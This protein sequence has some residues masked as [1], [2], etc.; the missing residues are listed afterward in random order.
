[1][2]KSL[3]ILW[4]V[5]LNFHTFLCNA[6]KEYIEVN[7]TILKETRQL[8]IQLPRN[9]DPNTE[10][11]YPLIFVFDGD[12]LF[13]PVA[14]IVD[15]LSY[16][17]EIPEAFVVGIKQDGQRIEDG[18]YDKNNFVPQGTG[19]DFF[20]FIQIEVLRYLRE[21][22]K[23]NE[24]SVAVGHNYMANFMNLFLF[25][26][27]NPFQGFINLSPD[28]PDGLVPY[29]KKELDVVN[30]KIWY[31][32]SI[33]S[34]DLDFLEKKAKTINKTFS[35]IYNE[36]VSFS[37]KQFKDTNHYSLVT[38]AIPF[39]L[40]EIFEIYGPI[41]NEEYES[42]LSKA[43]NP[44]D[45]LEDKYKSIYDL[46]GVNKTIRIKDIMLVAQ[47]IEE[48]KTPERYK[49][50]S[51]LV[52]ESYPKTMLS[53]YFLGKYYQEIG[54]PK[55]AIKAYQNAYAY[56]EAGGITKDMVIEEADKLKEIFGY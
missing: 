43:K 7:S 3:L 38:Y 10:K 50:L 45:Y 49:D 52:K 5:L 11:T 18:N 13:E 1:M 42:K 44:V 17:E 31:S 9:Y 20:D 55:K 56:D 54:K 46:Y 27:Q 4:V 51:K 2:K 15:Y 32:V 14:G 36:D 22:Y 19:A 29:I 53:D 41:T 40:T 48:N 39:S 21:N 37:Y 26:D 23:L 34:N 8:K 16:W 33:G 35:T 28:I 25:S 47:L 24:F 12:Y 30:Q 6:Q